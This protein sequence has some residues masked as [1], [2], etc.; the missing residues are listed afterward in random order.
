MMFIF[1]ILL[2]SALPL[3]FSYLLL[4]L[5]FIA[6]SPSEIEDCLCSLPFLDT[7]EKFLTGL[8][9][10]QMNYKNEFH[11]TNG[12]YSVMFNYDTFGCNDA[13]NYIREISCHRTVVRHDISAAYR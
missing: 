10:T 5:V 8:H 13:T 11:L 7:S 12:L 6:V 4:D 2:L 1:R 9:F 3:L